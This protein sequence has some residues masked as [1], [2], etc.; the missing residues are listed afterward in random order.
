MNSGKRRP[1]FNST[2]QSF[3]T[4]GTFNDTFNMTGVNFN[5]GTD[6]SPENVNSVDH[7]IKDFKFY[8][9]KYNYNKPGMMEMAYRVPDNYV[10]QTLRNA[11]KIT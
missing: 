7:N 10:G 1:D 4:M 8:S 6:F 3:G 11:T 2:L 5:S 9:T